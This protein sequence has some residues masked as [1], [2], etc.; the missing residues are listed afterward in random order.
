MAG[1]KPA[2]RVDLFLNLHILSTELHKQKPFQP[3]SKLVKNECISPP[4]LIS[5][6]QFTL[7]YQGSI[8]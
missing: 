3:Y 6:I 7:C 2:T 8:K 5:N 1:L 4:L